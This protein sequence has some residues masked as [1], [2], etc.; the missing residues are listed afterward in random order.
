MIKCF[1]DHCGRNITGERRVTVKM[2]LVNYYGSEA[3]VDHLVGIEEEKVLCP[4]CAAL[5]R[6]FFVNERP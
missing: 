3:M 2:E 1:C 4:H 5:V 6:G